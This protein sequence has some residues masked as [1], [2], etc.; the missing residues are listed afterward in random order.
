MTLHAANDTNFSS[1]K[2]SNVIS[3]V[4]NVKS[5][6]L[7]AQIEKKLSAYDFEKVA[8]EETKKHAISSLQ[9]LETRA[10]ALERDAQS[11]IGDDSLNKRRFLRDAKNLREGKEAKGLKSQIQ[12]I[13]TLLSILEEPTK[14]AA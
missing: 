1:S 7:R 5:S 11:I 6:A 12:K 10:N 9:A 13:N 14:K 8:L 3:L 2:K 4:S